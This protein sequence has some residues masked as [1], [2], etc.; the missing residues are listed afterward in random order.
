MDRAHTIA[1]SDRVALARLRR[2]LLL[3]LTAGTAGLA[4]ELAFIGDFEDPLQ[5]VPVVL[6]VFGLVLLNWHAASPRPASKRAVQVLMT[7]F[8]VSGLPGVGLHYRGNEEFEREMYPPMAGVELA[9]KNADWRN[10]R[11]GTWI[12]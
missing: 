9:G 12:N 11:S 8:V 1:V 7:L 2:F 4:L 3:T 6:L 10:T 5:L